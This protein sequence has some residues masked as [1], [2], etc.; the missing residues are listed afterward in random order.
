MDIALFRRRRIAAQIRHVVGVERFTKPAPR[1]ADR[2]GELPD[3]VELPIRSD[4]RDRSRRRCASLAVSI[5]A[6][7]DS[8]SSIR[9]IAICSPFDYTQDAEREV[10]RFFKQTGRVI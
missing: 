1:V 6:A 2:P 5:S 8:R 9:V 4:P 3:G 7:I 10:S